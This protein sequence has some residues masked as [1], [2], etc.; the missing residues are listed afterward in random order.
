MLR[1]CYIQVIKL[2]SVQQIGLSSKAA[3]LLQ[4]FCLSLTV[5]AHLVLTGCDG[6][7]MARTL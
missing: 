3:P 6:F 7:L 2:Q 1:L 4:T 5:Q